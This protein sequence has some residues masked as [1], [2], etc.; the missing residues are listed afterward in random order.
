VGRRGER[1]EDCVDLSWTEQERSPKGLCGF[2]PFNNIKT[3]GLSDRDDRPD[4]TPRALRRSRCRHVYMM[5]SALCACVG[6]YCRHLLSK[7]F[8]NMRSVYNLPRWER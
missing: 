8:L 4:Q 2:T 1:G 6:E 3:I 7:S 5:A